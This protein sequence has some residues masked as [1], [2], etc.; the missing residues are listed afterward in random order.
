MSV[1]FDNNG[2]IT[3]W[4]VTR[5]PLDSNSPMDPAIQEKVE[6][7]YILVEDFANIVVGEASSPI[8][9]INCRTQEW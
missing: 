6:S 8:T 2:T 5:T 4:N 3:S 9:A 1:N 7:D